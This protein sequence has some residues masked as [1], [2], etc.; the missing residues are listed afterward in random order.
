MG[1]TP[2]RALVAG[3]GIGG[4][5]AAIGLA[6]AGWSVSL[7]ERAAAFREVGAGLQISPNASRVLRWMGL[8][9]TVD[10]HAFHPEA[11]EMR[12][13][14]SGDLIYRAPLGAAAEARWGA[15]YLHVHRA[16][17]LGVLIGAARSAGVALRTGD[18][19]GTYSNRTDGVRVSMADGRV[20]T[21]DLCIAAD[22]LRSSLRATLNGPEAP[23]FSGQVVWRG[24]VP[25]DRL[26]EGLVTPTATVWAG[27]GRHLV[28]YYLRRGTLV[29]IV[30][31]EDR[32]G[33]VDERWSIRD[34]AARL[35]A[36]FVG[37]DPRVTGLL[38]HVED[39]F[40]WGLFLR[41]EQVRWADGRVAL[42]GDAA[43]AM[44]PFMAQGA[45]MALEDV[46]V[47]IR[48]LEAR[49]TI[50]EALRAYEEARWSRVVRVQD[51]SADNGRL[52]HMDTTLARM[53]AWTPMMLASRFAPW[54]G[55]MQLDWLYGHDV[56]RVRP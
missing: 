3:G 17:L 7:H 29:N 56:T 31:A 13:G 23:E 40:I 53:F 37:W 6:R 48:A 10:A 19:V 49:D 9:E 54:L 51:R 27:P 14:R 33:W 42:L 28:T 20:E 39:P 1:V 16:D 8:L 25:A 38:E 55:T 35:R 52:F 44:L 26:P 41:R 24:T 34:D 22:G 12:D 36:S 4:M 43:H 21:A 30:A 32:A 5:A 15:P 11:A 47:L 2:G 18:A 46:A 45:A 50:E